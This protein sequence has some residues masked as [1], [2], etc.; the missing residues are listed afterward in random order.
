M[1]DITAENPLSP[2]GGLTIEFVMKDGTVESVNLSGNI[3]FQ[4]KW[5]KPATVV[6]G[7]IGDLVRKYMK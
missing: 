2:D 4:N 7:T 6:S 1:E 5:Y 3:C